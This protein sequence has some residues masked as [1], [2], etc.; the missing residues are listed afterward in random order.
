MLLSCGSDGVLVYDWNDDSGLEPV[1]I[2]HFTSS[3]AYKAKLYNG[4]T[5]IVGTEL[6]LE[7]FNIGE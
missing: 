7:L 1:F 4:N 2:G 6:G 3:Y 5:V